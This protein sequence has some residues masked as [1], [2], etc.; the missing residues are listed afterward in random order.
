MALHYDITITGKVQN[1]GFRFYA[2][3]TAHELEITGFVKN[4]KDGSVHIEAEGEEENLQQFIAWC[5]KGPPWAAVEA[6]VVNQSPVMQLRGFL[7]E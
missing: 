5:H 1:V 2:Q 6:V 7:V 4:N 3:K